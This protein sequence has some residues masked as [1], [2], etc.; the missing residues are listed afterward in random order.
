M[1]TSSNH[2]ESPVGYEAILNRTQPSSSSGQQAPNGTAPL[3]PALF[4]EKLLHPA[5]TFVLYLGGL[6]LFVTVWAKLAPRVA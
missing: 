4:R 3:M 6:T 1:T 2:S 5:S